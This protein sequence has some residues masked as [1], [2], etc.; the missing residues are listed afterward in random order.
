MVYHTHHYVIDW[1]KVQTLDDIK[2]L[3]KAID[4]AFEPNHK[5]IENIQDLVELK[6]KEVVGFLTTANIE[7][8]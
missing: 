3:L 1:D 8:D 6:E 2:R 4:I 7:L 5:E